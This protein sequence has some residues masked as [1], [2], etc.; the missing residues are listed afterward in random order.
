MKGNSRG[1]THI[2]L[3]ALER[4]WFRTYEGFEGFGSDLHSPTFKAAR[5]HQCLALIFRPELKHHDVWSDC[6][7]MTTSYV[8]NHADAHVPG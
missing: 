2:Q 1:M 4:S 6:F 3:P 7:H 8:H 5:S